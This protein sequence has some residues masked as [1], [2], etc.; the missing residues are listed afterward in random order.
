MKVIHRKHNMENIL[1]MVKK[2]RKYF[3]TYHVKDSDWRS[4][5]RITS[6]GYYAF[7]NEDF[8]YFEEKEANYWGGSRGR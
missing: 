6:D 7:I 5:F 2:G 3:Y 1:D 8:E 4:K